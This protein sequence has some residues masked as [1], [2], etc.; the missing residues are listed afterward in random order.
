MCNAGLRKQPCPH[1]LQQHAVELLDGLFGAVVT[2]HQVFTG[3]ARGAGLNAHLCG[4]RRLVVKQQ[5]VFAP[6]RQIVQ[7]DAQTFAAVIRVAQ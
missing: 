1:V 2:L 3:A 7:A 6:P 4:E 5:P